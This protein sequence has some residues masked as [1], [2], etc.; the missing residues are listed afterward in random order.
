[1]RIKRFCFKRWQIVL[2]SLV[3]VLGITWLLLK[4]LPSPSLNAFMQRQNSTRFY[5][6]NGNLLHILALDEGLRREWYD[7]ED[8]PE[9]VQN[10]FIEAEDKNFYHHPGV[11]VSAVF[12]AASQNKEA[13]RIV[14]G[15][16]TITMQ[17]VRIIYPRKN[18]TVTLGVKIKEVFRALYLEIKLTK[19]QIL[20]LYLNSVPFGKQVEGVGS[21]S[22]SF[23][24]V[25]PEQLTQQQIEVLAKIPRRPAD[26]APEKVYDYPS[27]CP[28][29]I[30]YVISRYAQT[31][32]VMPNDMTLSISV[33]WNELT[34][35]FI[36]LK[37]NEFADARIHNGA[38]LVVNNATGEVL[39]WC[40]NASFDDKEHNGEID[41]VLVENQPG[42][43]MKPFLYARSLERGFSP[44]EVLP[45][46]PLDFG[47]AQVYVPLNFN[48]RYNGPV[49]MR[50]ALASSLNIPAVYVLYRIGVDDYMECLD[51]LGFDSLKGTRDSTGL[52]IALG[53]SEVSLLEMVRAFSVFPRDGKVLQD[54]AVVP[55]AAQEGKRVYA[56]DTARI[57]CDMLSDKNARVLGF[58]NA[59]VFETSYP[60]MFKTGTS[61]QY[62]NIIALGAT[63]ELTVG[64]WMGNFEGETVVG[65]TGSSIPAAV[66]RTILDELTKTYGAQQFAQPESY[67]QQNI[68]TLSGMKAT[69][70]CPSVSREY[71]AQGR[72]GNF[73]PCTWHETRNGKTIIKYPSE[74]QHWAAQK[75]ISGE[76]QLDGSELSFLYPRNNAQFI[77]DPTIKP[78]AQMLAVE[79]TGGHHTS[80][81]LYY[82]GKN[83][84][85]V[86]DVFS[87][88]IA[89][90]RGTHTLT[91]ECGSERTSIT[92]TVK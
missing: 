19:K 80:A 24:G 53:S 59:K 54:V 61:N 9:D 57:L 58:G 92:F 63:S 20:E 40:G 65:Q 13:G 33:E 17:L 42:S 89:L 50:V 73:T 4:L 52:S 77:F 75:N 26:Y 6:R 87:W 16:S 36:Q 91:V 8:I 29:F 62:Q 47:G 1:M 55:S 43:S 2:L 79:V 81:T 64:V 15:A 86:S 11:D 14:S 69:E 39:V 74:Y 56:K 31:Q 38:A 25:T 3:A 12:R 84:G 21:A 18:G 67:V 83:K 85:T 68:C 32:S 45:D 41:G 28:H 49:R 88:H 46:I 48:N 22:R 78:D 71:I 10:A 44:S 27:R 70:D 34:E 5:D 60:S 90:E 30:Q 37:L 7:L 35:R 82:D 66:V 76:I 72:A 51:S 23:F